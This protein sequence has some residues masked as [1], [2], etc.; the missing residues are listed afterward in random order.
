MHDL[1]DLTN[2]KSASG[3]GISGYL[4]MRK[5][6]KRER[7]GRKDTERVRESVGHREREKRTCVMVEGGRERETVM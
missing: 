3:L 4:A 2:L 5:T 1:N 7:M 6:R